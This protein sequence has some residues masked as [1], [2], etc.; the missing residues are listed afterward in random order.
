MV[1]FRRR[2]FLIAAGALIA[3]PVRVVAQQAGRVYRIGYLQIAPRNAQVHLIEAFE[4][5]LRELGY[6]VGRNVL[7][8][9]R[10]ADGKT[11]RLPGLAAELVRL[12]VDVIVTGVNANIRAALE[13]TK[14]IPIVT[15]VALYPVEDGLVA[16]LGRPGGNVTGLTQHAGDEVAKRLQL[17]REAAR[18][19]TRV[20]ALSGAGMSY[21]PFMFKTVEGAA[22]GLGMTFLP[23]EIRGPQDVERAFAEVERTQTGGMVIFSGPIP[24]A[25]RASIISMAAKKKLPA[26]WGDRQSVLDGGLMSYGP[27]GADLFRRAAGYVDR[28]LKGAKP[29]DLP[30]EQP[31][32]FVL[33]INLKTAKALGLSIPQELLLRADEVIE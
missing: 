4:R 17:L 21:N 33:A 6:S 20:A 11:E 16:S 19:L 9:Y 29:A 27:D 2:R 14:T 7:I 26:I 12:N 15:A 3:A 28:I 13:A 31:T 24:L 1:K 23:L 8:E 22:R 5:G 10:F 30:F 18:G 32:R 25:N